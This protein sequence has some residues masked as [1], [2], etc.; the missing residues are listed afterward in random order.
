M[1]RRMRESSEA[2]RTGRKW[3]RMALRGHWLGIFFARMHGPIAHRG[4]APKGP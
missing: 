3:L 1:E 4:D 2:R